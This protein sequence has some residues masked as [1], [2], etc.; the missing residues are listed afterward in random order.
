MEESSSTASEDDDD[1]ILNVADGLGDDF[2]DEEDKIDRKE[3]DP[4]LDRVD[5]R[6]KAVDVSNTE[7]FAAVRKNNGRE[8][9]IINEVSRLSVLDQSAIDV[10]E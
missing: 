7:S 2:R 4:L 3:F 8:M 9:I 5:R 1:A 6:K 10:S